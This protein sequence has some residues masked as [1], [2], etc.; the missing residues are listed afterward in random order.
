MTTRNFALAIG[1]LYL[2]LGVLG[3][4]PGL[5]TTPPAEAPSMVM[6]SGYGYLL[7]LFPVNVLHNLVHVAI[8][9]WALSAYRSLS[10]SVIFSRRLMSIYAVLTVMGLFPL[11]DTM[12]GLLPIFGHNVWL[13]AVTAVIAGYFGYER[14]VKAVPVERKVPRAA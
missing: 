6:R 10:G 11:L 14:A 8:G 1:I 4:F 5:V 7:G 13:H 2:L 3:F 12:F 9:I